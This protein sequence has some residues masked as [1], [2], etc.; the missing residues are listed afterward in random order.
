MYDKMSLIAAEEP[1][2]LVVSGDVYRIALLRTY[3]VSHQWANLTDDC[4]R[5]WHI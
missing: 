2:I 3:D 1:V 5:V 4:Q